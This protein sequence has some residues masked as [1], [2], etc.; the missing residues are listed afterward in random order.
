[1]KIKG[2][3]KRDGRDFLVEQV[4]ETGGE[5]PWD[6]QP[7]NSDYAVTLVDALLDAKEAG[8]R[9]ERA[10]ETIADL[11]PEF[12]LD[13]TSVLGDVKASLARLRQQV[14]RQG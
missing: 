11:A 14:V 1:M 8:S 12:S 9:F 10:L 7:F 3:C 6:G 4:I 5:C 2:T 13:E